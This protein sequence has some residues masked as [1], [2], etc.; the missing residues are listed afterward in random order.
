MR[1]ITSGLA[2]LA[3]AAVLVA[4]SDGGTSSSTARAFRITSADQLLSGRT[5]RGRVGDYK[6]HNDKVAFV[7]QDVG[8]ASGYQRY[9]GLA[10]RA[11]DLGG[12]G[13]RSGR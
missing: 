13:D 12:R 4:C 11:P 5:A 7:I 8:L 9:G 6:I 2:S 10:R 3:V 1:R